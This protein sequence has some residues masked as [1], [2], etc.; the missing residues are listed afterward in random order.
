M[1]VKAMTVLAAAMLYSIA[2][3]AHDCSGGMGGGMDATGNQCNAEV[4]YV[5]TATSTPEATSP[6]SPAAHGVRSNGATVHTSAH[7]ASKSK[8]ARH[9]AKRPAHGLT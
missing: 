3:H 9:A 4:V 5:D 8:N 1:K 6:L 2:A 7:A